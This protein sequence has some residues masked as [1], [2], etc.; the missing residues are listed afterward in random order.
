MQFFVEELEFHFHA[1][2]GNGMAMGQQLRGRLGAEK[3]RSAGY[4]EKIAFWKLFIPDELYR[5][6]GAEEDACGPGGTQTDLFMS[7]VA[8]S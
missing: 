6:G 3:T 4:V 1:I 8:H 5:R 2:D 7:Y